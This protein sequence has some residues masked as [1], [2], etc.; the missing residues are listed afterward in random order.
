VVRRVPLLPSQP[1]PFA[2][3][4]ERL[5]ALPRI[6]GGAER[7]PGDGA[8]ALAA[9]LARVVPTTSKRSAKPRR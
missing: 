6:E 1:I 8:D 3:L 5:V 7:R 2:E 4:A 9:F